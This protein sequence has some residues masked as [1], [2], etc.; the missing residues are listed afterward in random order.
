MAIRFRRWYEHNRRALKDIEAK[1]KQ[2]GIPQNAP[3]SLMRVIVATQLDTQFATFAAAVG[4]R[5][6]ETMLVRSLQYAAMTAPQ[7]GEIAVTRDNFAAIVLSRPWDLVGRTTGER[8]YDA[9]LASTICIPSADESAD[10]SADRSVDEENGCPQTGPRTCPRPPSPSPSVLPLTPPAP[11]EGDSASPYGNDHVRPREA[12][13]VAE[14]E[15][16]AKAASP[17]HLA[18][19]AKTLPE[20]V[21]MRG[22]Y[23]PNGHAAAPAVDP[24]AKARE[25]RDA[26]L[27]RPPPATPMRGPDVEPE[28]R[29]HVADQGKIERLKAEA[30]AKIAEME[31]GDDGCPL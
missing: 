10:E 20:G 6:A 4:G 29:P 28:P 14:A 16:L 31:R 22:G 12:R 17:E 8:V 11:R 23:V 1:R 27:H 24:A 19:I 30:L 9:L 13:R 18:E 3:L 5:F 15:R 25:I 2:R 26:L 21:A 7:R